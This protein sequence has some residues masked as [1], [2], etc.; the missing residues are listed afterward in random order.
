[1][2]LASY[3]GQVE[4]DTTTKLLHIISAALLFYDTFKHLNKERVQ[5]LVHY[6]GVQFREVASTS[7]PVFYR[8]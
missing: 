7:L 5:G 1:M 6:G 4:C 2:T 3:L 8:W